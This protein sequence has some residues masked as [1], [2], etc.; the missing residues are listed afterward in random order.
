MLSVEASSAALF[1]DPNK[2]PVSR[3]CG[4]IEVLVGAGLLRE[5][6]FAGDSANVRAEG[7]ARLWLFEKSGGG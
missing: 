2:D 4:R 3:R 5:L 1:V 6:A 7:H